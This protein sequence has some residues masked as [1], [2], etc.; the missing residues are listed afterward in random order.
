VFLLSPLMTKIERWL[1][2][3]AA[4]LLVV[5]M[6]F[7]GYR[8]GGPVITRQLVD[9][10]AKLPD[11]KENIKTP[12]GGVFTKSLRASRGTKKDL[13]CAETTTPA[14]AKP[15]KSATLP[16]TSARGRIGTRDGDFQRE[17]HGARALP[18]CAGAGSA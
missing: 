6:D 1:G 18:P 9:P 17:S 12:T 8:G 3:I 13:P 2:R 4:G 14:A 11:Y 16:E 10:V 5:V 15:E 7:R